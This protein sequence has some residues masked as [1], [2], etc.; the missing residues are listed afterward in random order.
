[1]SRSLKTTGGLVLALMLSTPMAAAQDQIVTVALTYHQPS[2]K[3]PRPNFSPK[4]TQVTL[5]DVPA[6]MPLPGDPVG[7][8]VL[9]ENRTGGDLLEV[10]VTDVLPLCLDLSGFDPVANPSQVMACR[11]LVLDDAT[12]AEI[13]K[14]PVKCQEYFNNSRSAFFCARGGDGGT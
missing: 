8:T 6:S 13:C 14:D 9:V 12:I 3:A 7:Y 10:S 4:G 11:A 2:D 1:M 5:A